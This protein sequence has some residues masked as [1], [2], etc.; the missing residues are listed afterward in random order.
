MHVLVLHQPHEHAMVAAVL[1]HALWLLQ[2]A[3]EGLVT[4]ALRTTSWLQA[5]GAC[6][7]ACTT[8]LQRQGLLS[9]HVDRCVR[10]W[11]IR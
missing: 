11:A 8:A 1:Q 6:V 4:E 3:G 7:A 5:V 10:R 9:L 2:C